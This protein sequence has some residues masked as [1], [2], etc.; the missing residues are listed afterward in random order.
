MWDIQLWN[1]GHQMACIA[2]HSKQ[3]DKMR[4][5]PDFRTFFIIRLRDCPSKM[6]DIWQ[7]CVIIKWCFQHSFNWLLLQYNIGFSP[8]CNKN[9]NQK[10]KKKRICHLIMPFTWSMVCLS[11]CDFSTLSLNCLGSWWLTY[12]YTG[13]SSFFSNANEISRPWR[14]GARISSYPS[15]TGCCNQLVVVSVK[16][17]INEDTKH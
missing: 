6:W 13:V 8:F 17:E 2:K 16:I 4:D 9:I 5:I 7:V 3:N 14:L 12:L 15:M 1:E 11:L 10:S